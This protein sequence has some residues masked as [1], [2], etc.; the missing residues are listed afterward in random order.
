MTL[1]I[2]FRCAAV[3]QP[4]EV[5]HD[6]RHFGLDVPTPLALDALR[7]VVATHEACDCGAEV[8]LC[9]GLSVADGVVTREVTK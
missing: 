3:A 9:S 7:A 6:P 4:Y 1:A 2:R 5:P 8:L